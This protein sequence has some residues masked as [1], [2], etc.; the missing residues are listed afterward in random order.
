MKNKKLDVI[1]LGRAAVDLYSEQIGA[2]LEDVNSFKK[3][4]G[5]SSANIAFGAARMGL[6]SAMLTRVGDEHMGRFVRQELARA[7]VDVSHVVTD[8]ER[9]TGLV[10]LGIKDKDTFPLIFYRENCADMAIS[11]SDFDEAYIASA[12][13]LLIT[14]THFSTKGTDQAARTAIQ[15]AKAND[16]KVVV[17][18]DY[19]PVLWGLTGKG[20][21]ENRFVSND[22]VT[23]HLLSIMPLCDLVVGTEEEFH[24]AGGC[25]DTIECLKRIR[26]VSSAE[27]VVKRG[28]LGCSVFKG[29]IPD[30]LDDGIT[31]YG[32]TASL[33]MC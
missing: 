14:G 3:Y 19:R 27:F 1:C 11:E 4:L 23:Q 13:A 2:P 10:L 6:K 5:G 7:G 8:K 26:K 21:G 33:W 25:E 16:T 9:L 15:Y 17:D 28:A 31:R 18:I 24:I 32:V 20:E 12:K 30:T 22:S 29:E